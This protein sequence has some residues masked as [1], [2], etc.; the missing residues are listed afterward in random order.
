MCSVVF[1]RTVSWTIYACDYSRYL[2]ANGRA[3]SVFLRAFGGIFGS[4]TWTMVLGAALTLMAGGDPLTG[5]GI[6]LPDPLL[7]TVLSVLLGGSH[8]QSHFNT[9]LLMASYFV[10]PWPAIPLI[11]FYRTHRGGRDYPVPAVFQDRTG[12]YRGIRPRALP[13]FFPGA[14]V[15]FMA[16]DACTW[17]TGHLVDGGSPFGSGAVRHRPGSGPAG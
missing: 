10:I 6:V 3:R 2:P 13:A 15:P 16:T 14:S 9:F 11:D 7:K 4:A 12:P 8:F 1:S 17:P 5:L